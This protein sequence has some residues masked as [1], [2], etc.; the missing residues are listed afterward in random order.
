MA[1]EKYA[2][3]SK[4]ESSVHGLG[5]AHATP[6]AVPVKLSVTEGGVWSDT[7]LSTLDAWFALPGPSV[8][9]LAGTCARESQPIYN[10]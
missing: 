2:V 7:T 5:L 6:A 9:T 3:T 10:R 8:A 1:S 4:G